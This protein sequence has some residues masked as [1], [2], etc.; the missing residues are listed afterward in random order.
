ME[1]IAM[2]VRVKYDLKKYLSTIFFTQE[3]NHIRS[4]DVLIGRG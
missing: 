2:T 1:V 3:M 4:L